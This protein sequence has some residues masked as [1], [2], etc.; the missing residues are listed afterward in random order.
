[1]SFAQ[2]GPAEP[3]LGYFLPSYLPYTWQ[4]YPLLNYS[5]EHSVEF[6]LFP[7]LQGEYSVVHFH[8]F[9][10]RVVVNRRR[11]H[12]WARTMIA[13]AKRE[14]SGCLMVLGLARGLSIVKAS[15]TCH[16]LWA[17]R[18]RCLPCPMR[19]GLLV[20]LDGGRYKRRGSH[21]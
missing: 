1:M 6:L 18:G 19:L 13:V 12:R 4:D 10:I 14:D 20:V 8:T 17:G 5:A 3:G 21:L 11:C 15:S 2:C 16:L 9:G 7:C